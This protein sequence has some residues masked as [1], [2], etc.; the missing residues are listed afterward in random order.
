MLSRGMVLSIRDKRHGAIHTGQEAWCYPYGTR[1]MV[2]SIRDKRCYPV[3]C[4]VAVGRASMRHMRHETCVPPCI[5]Y[6]V[7]RR[8]HA[9]T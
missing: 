8:V 9:M 1:G 5:P 7:M 6:G 4:V 2:L 3:L